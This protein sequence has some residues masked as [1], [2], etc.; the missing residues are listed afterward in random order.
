MSRA[1]G[2]DAE[3]GV[4]AAGANYKSKLF[5]FGAVDYFCDDVINIFYAEGRIS[6]TFADKLGLL[7]AAQY[8]DQRSAGENL[9][10]GS[11]FFTNQ[12]GL[13]GEIGYEGALMTLAYTI[14]GSGANLRTPWGS[15]PG[16]TSV[17][18]QDFNRAGEE[19]FMLRLAYDC[20]K[21]GLDGLTTSAL[22]VHGWNRVDP[23]TR[24]S[25]FNED[26]YDLDIQWRAKEGVLKGFWPRLRYAHV[27]QRNGNDQSINDLRVI[28]NYEISVL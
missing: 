26:E 8:S 28:V 15:H 18:V 13:K 14:D 9:L 6:H 4:W 17:Q 7:F 3:R 5:S 21:I 11:S 16:Y 10:T 19:A 1:A 25:V 27:E 23:A 2:A 12:V 24:A 22:W 20:S